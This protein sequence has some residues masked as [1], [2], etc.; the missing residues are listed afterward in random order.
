MQELC[1]L[2]NHTIS[3]YDGQGNELPPGHR[4]ILGLPPVSYAHFIVGTILVVM[5]SNQ[6]VCSPWMNGEYPSKA[7]PKYFKLPLL[8]MYSLL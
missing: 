3:I 4:S 8:H 2:L 6:N 7:K 5:Y 1:I